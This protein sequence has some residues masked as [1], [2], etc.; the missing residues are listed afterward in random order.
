MK[1][2]SPLAV[3]FGAVF[4]YV[5]RSGYETFTAFGAVFFGEDVL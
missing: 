3:V 2:T 5:L 1:I 4:E